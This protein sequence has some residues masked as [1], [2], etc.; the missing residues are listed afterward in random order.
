M[1]LRY[2]YDY[3]HRN[4]FSLGALIKACVDRNTVK[5]AE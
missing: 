5:H 1:E 3:A 4:G 2:L